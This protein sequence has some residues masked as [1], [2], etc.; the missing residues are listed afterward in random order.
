MD[1]IQVT[2]PVPEVP[3]DVSELTKPA[4]TSLQGLR[5][6]LCDRHLYV[7]A[8]V[9]ITL[10]TGGELV[11]CGNCARK[12]FGFEHTKFNQPENRQKGSDH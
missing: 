8:V 1:N 10:A 3:D 7:A 11:L 2:V 6:E 5:P 12:H 4:F 9:K